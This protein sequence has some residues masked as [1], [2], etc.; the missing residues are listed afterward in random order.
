MSIIVK[1]LKKLYDGNVILDGV[2]NN[3]EKN[4]ITVILGENGSGKTT[5]LKC[6][7]KLLI[8]DF[9]SVQYQDK[10]A[11]NQEKMISLLLESN[12]Y[13]L[14]NLTVIENIK[15][16][17]A[18]HGIKYRERKDIVQKYLEIFS[19]KEHEFFLVSKLSQG[20]RQKVALVCTLAHDVEY[21]FLDEPTA[22]LDTGAIDDLAKVINSLCDRTFVIA[23]H[24]E[25]FEKLLN[26]NTLT[27]SN[28]KLLSKECEE[29]NR[30]EV[31]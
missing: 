3:I 11:K 16:I 2:S 29:V 31:S 4:T 21:V 23:T 19:I 8:P 22:A 26:C 24:D 27:F 25:N 28:G 15:Y 20:V 12:K 14:Q 30:L 9:G 5:Y 10:K 1:N 18:I 7:S 13:L 17:L 6:L